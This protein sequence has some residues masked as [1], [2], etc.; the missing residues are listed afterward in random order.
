MK[1]V[2]E[3]LKNYYKISIEIENEAILN[4]KLDTKIDNYEFKDVILMLELALG[5]KIR[6]EQDKYIMSG[7]GC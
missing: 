7:E 3:D 6:E 2:V 4:C 1:E 5:I